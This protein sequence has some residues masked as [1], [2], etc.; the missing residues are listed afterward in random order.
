MFVKANQTFEHMHRINCTF[1]DFIEREKKQYYSLHAYSHTR[2]H[3]LCFG[4]CLIAHVNTRSP[5][6]S[7]THLTN[8]CS[9][10][11]RARMCV[12]KL[13]VPRWC[14]MNSSN[15]IKP[16]NYTRICTGGTALE[17]WQNTLA[18]S[19]KQ[20]HTCTTFHPLGL[21]SRP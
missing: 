4:W 11:A 1:C 3:T 10:G 8:T 6:S 7:C 16:H 5:T 20:K 21:T 17:T 18:H 9:P 2:T 14:F 19:H 13:E 12:C 15:S